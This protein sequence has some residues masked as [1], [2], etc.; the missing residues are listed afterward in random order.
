MTELLTNRIAP[1]RSPFRILCV[2]GAGCGAWV[3]RGILEWFEQAGIPASALSLRGHGNSEGADRLH[4]FRITDYVEDVIDAVGASKPPPVLLGHSMGGL[5]VQKLLETRNFPGAVLLAS[6]PVDGMLRDGLRMA[7]RWPAQTLRSVLRRSLLELYDTDERARWFLFSDATDI[8]L[9]REVR[10]KMGEESWRAI[11]DMAFLAR[12]KPAMV[13][14]PILVL[15][16]S[17]D[18]MV[19]RASNA[20][21]AAAYNTETKFF[22]CCGH[23][24]MLESVWPS[25]AEAIRDWCEELG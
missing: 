17:Q 25:V 1:E 6:T 3:W 15:A 13:K 23:M 22:D 18:N 11:L 8:S 2:H 9:V 16:G 14:T 21:T 24:M 4:E 7:R 10:E 5:V 12:P 20:R 19:S